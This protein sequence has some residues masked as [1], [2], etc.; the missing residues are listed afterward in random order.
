MDFIQKGNSE[1][2]QPSMCLMMEAVNSRSVLLVDTMYLEH[3]NPW[4]SPLTEMAQQVK[5]PEMLLHLV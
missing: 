2:P 5:C 3:M 4:L 1:F